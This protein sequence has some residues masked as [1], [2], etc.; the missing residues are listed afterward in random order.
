[1]RSIFQATVNT[2]AAGRHARL[3]AVVGEGLVGLRHAEDVVLA[4]VGAALLG[5]RVEQ[6]V[7]EP[8]RHGLLA[9]VAGGLDEPAHGERAGAALRP[10]DGH[11]G[12]RTADAAGGGPPPPARGP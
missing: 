10:L 1:M 2:G 4:L 11:P 7:R 5:L 8:L 3:P 6:L 12:G 9:A